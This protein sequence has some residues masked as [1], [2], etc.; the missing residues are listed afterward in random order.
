MDTLDS[1]GLPVANKMPYLPSSMPDYLTH[2][3][4]HSDPFAV[5]DFYPGAGRQSFIDG[6]HHQVLFGAGLLVVGAAEGVGKT[7]LCAQLKKSFNDVPANV[8]SICLQEGATLQLF[9]AELA[10]MLGMSSLAAAP[11]GQALSEL[12]RHLQTQREDGALSVLLIDDAH[13]LDEQSLST[14]VGLLQGQAELDRSVCVVLFAEPNFLGRLAVADIGDL[15]LHDILLEAFDLDDLR[16]YL[17]W[18]FAQAGDNAVIPY[19]NS[20]LDAWLLESAGNLTR[21][22]MKAQQWLMESASTASAVAVE[23]PT[24][25]PADSKSELKQLP[26]L[27]LGAIIL[28]SSV[29]LIAYLFRADSQELTEP[30]VVEVLADNP[31]QLHSSDAVA[32]DIVEQLPV[33]AELVAVD[34][35]VADGGVA[36]EVI[37]P[38]SVSESSDALSPKGE[39]VSSV[40]ATPAE[41]EPAEAVVDSVS[42]EVFVEVKAKPV[43]R[44]LVKGPATA[45]PLTTDEKKLLAFK[46]QEYVLQVM[47]AS[48]RDSVA[49]FVAQ[50]PNRHKMYVFSSKRQ[51]DDWYVVVAGPYAGIE[52]ARAAIGRLPSN[53]RSAGPWPRSLADVQ[54]KIREN[55]DI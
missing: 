9:V 23:T 39:Q 8:C 47:A 30:E 51:G 29:L 2:F 33:E 14:L 37:E 43:E 19:K 26:V 53:Q 34:A 1:S 36:F 12:R 42:E 4:L 54:L 21:I 38:P 31:A 24:L 18:R 27:H 45:S 3:D 11:L 52:A 28:L 15:L 50:Q 49:K 22:H 6:L 55:R 41:N 20:D 10:L 40:G 17:Q 35:S 5:A 48:S 44:E 32:V 25:A 13:Y 16:A 7:R 46:E